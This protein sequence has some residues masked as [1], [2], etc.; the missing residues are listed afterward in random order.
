MTTLARIAAFAI[1]VTLGVVFLVYVVQVEPRDLTW[2]VFVLTAAAWASVAVLGYYAGKNPPIGSLTER[3]F[4][5]L[6]IALLGTVACILVLNTDR[7][8][9]ILD[10]QQASLLFRLA[11][12][13]VLSVPSVWLVLW[14]TGRLGG[15]DP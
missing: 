1:T 4:V 6:T 11:I 15:T 9:P 3:A 8:H 5:S 2:L 14:L 10:A 7:G 13:A 12:L